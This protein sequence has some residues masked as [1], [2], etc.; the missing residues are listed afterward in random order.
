MSISQKNKS[1]VIVNEVLSLDEVSQ[2]ANRDDQNDD[3]YSDTFESESGEDDEGGLHGIL[4]QPIA[5][6]DTQAKKLYDKYGAMHRSP[7]SDEEET[8]IQD[9]NQETIRYTAAASSLRLSNHLVSPPYMP[10]LTH[11]DNLSS[12]E[13]RKDTRAPYSDEDDSSV[14]ESPNRKVA[15]G[16]TY[17][18]DEL[19]GSSD[20][21]VEDNVLSRHSGAAHVRSGS[22]DS[23]EYSNDTNQIFPTDLTT[24][25]RLK[26]KSSDTTA[27][28]RGLPITPQAHMEG[29][30][31]GF[32][33]SAWSNSTS[34]SVPVS[35]PHTMEM[36]WYAAMLRDDRSLLSPL[37]GGSVVENTLTQSA[38]HSKTPLKVPHFDDATD[39]SSIHSADHCMIQ[40]PPISNRIGRS[41]SESC[42]D[43]NDMSLP[44]PS[45]SSHSSKASPFANGKSKLSSKASPSQALSPEL[46]I[47]STPS[48]P[49]LNV[50]TERE[51][52]PSSDSSEYETPLARPPRARTTS[53]GSASTPSVSGNVEK[54]PP[55]A[56]FQSPPPGKSPHT[57][58][59][60]HRAA[61]VN[62][63][64]KASYASNTS[65]VG[66]NYG[67][68]PSSTRL[69]QP[70]SGVFFPL[71]DFETDSLS[72]STQ[73][74]QGQSIGDEGLCT[75][76]TSTGTSSPIELLHPWVEY[77]SEEG[78]PYFYN[79]VTGESTWERPDGYKASSSEGIV[80]H[81]VDS[82]GRG[83]EDTYCEKDEYES[84]IYGGD[85]YNTVNTYSEEKT[86]QEIGDAFDAADRE[87]SSIRYDNYGGDGEYKREASEEDVAKRHNYSDSGR[88]VVRSENPYAQ[89]QHQHPSHWQYQEKKN[90]EDTQLQSIDTVSSHDDDNSSKLSSC[91]SDGQVGGDGGS[92][93]SASLSNSMIDVKNK[94]GQSVLHISASA[95]NVDALALLVRVK[96]YGI[97]YMRHFH[98]KI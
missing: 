27:V 48:K 56:L 78:W 31:D 11:S 2:R 57:G 77:M 8:P 14:N 6:S 39:S 65:P 15:P 13:E 9:K 17:T 60:L 16:G 58:S 67:T 50:S 28:S 84:N 35:S 25:T 1:S 62:A 80:Q 29:L 81:G 51:L 40:S 93:A 33:S 91:T 61:L 82:S 83:Y 68:P 87:G 97:I 23:L 54:A 53:A 98:M 46:F 21:D 26:S 71:N 70:S 45:P 49:T 12:P 64:K 76:G 89:Q 20:E 32:E 95:C 72:A 34:S 30:G 74:P 96:S 22:N 75:A 19:S 79:E 3:I 92:V 90:L 52:T 88:V 4:Q 59:M 37:V 42:L 86:H 7:Y 85:T 10:T 69:P 47:S 55:I 44:R 66:S 43:L 36:Q 24:S 73:D 18:V 41:V 94:S 5:T 38:L 63:S